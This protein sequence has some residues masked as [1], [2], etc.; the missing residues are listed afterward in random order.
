V[1]QHSKPIT[2]RTIGYLGPSG[3][4][5]EEAARQFYPVEALLLPYPRI[6]A[7][8]R[9]VESGE[10]AEGIVPVENSL[11]GSVNIT[12]DTLAHEVNLRITGEI[13][14]PVKHHLLVK[15]G[16]KE[17]R[18]I[19]SHMQ[20]LAQCRQYLSRHYPEAQQRT[21]ESTAQAASMVATGESSAAAVGSMLAGQIYGLEIA[22]AEIQD[23]TH[24]STRFITI[25][26]ESPAFYPA[27]WKT[28]LVFQINGKHPG[29]L[30]E[31]LNEFAYRGVNL[32]KIESRPARTGLGV[33]I[34][35]ADC[36]GSLE[37]APVKKAFEAV[38]AKSLW[39]KNLG[40]YPVLSQG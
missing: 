17:V 3:T 25:C 27:K 35:F 2:I 23:H 10:I 4:H 24:N 36:D 18:T 11:E 33:Y 40:S 8:I 28:S 26:R 38:Q 15:P 39:F 16:T 20:A 14:W 7:V 5:S 21:V 34:F 12:L 6:D 31:I 19:L 1:V 32:T 22:A 37:D 29:S 30:C 9:A 13:I